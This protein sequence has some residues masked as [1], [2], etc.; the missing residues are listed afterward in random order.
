[1]SQ[2][3]VNPAL[4]VPTIASGPP[5]KSSCDICHSLFF[6]RETMFVDGAR[7]NNE[8]HLSRSRRRAITRGCSDSGRVANPKK[9]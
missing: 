1:M 8:D 6:S 2:A 9:G 3:I 5:A 7:A 4:G